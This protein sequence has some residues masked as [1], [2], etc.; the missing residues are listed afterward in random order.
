M[1]ISYLEINKPDKIG[2]YPNNLIAPRCNKATGMTCIYIQVCYNIYVSGVKQIVGFTS[3][4]NCYV[5]TD[6]YVFAMQLGYDIY[7]LAQAFM[8]DTIAG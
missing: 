2:F 7:S 1:V 4:P 6:E 8:N 3:E 5:N